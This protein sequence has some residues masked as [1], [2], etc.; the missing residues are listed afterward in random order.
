MFYI[1]RYS[2]RWNENNNDLVFDSCS[3]KFQFLVMRNEASSFPF[4][5]QNSAI[6]I[7]SYFTIINE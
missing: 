1:F 3:N 2:L 5:D 7:L 6:G 4:I